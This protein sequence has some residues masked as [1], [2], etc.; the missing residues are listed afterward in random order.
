MFETLKFII[1]SVQQINKLIPLIAGNKSKQNQ[2]QIA[3]G[4]WFT[5]TYGY[6]FQTT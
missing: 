4:H 6:T 2:K 5:S 1:K 3:Q